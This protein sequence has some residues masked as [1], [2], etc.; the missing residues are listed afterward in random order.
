MP[1]RNRHDVAV[2]GAG[3]A[4][5]AVAYALARRRIDVVILDASRRD[6]GLPGPASAPVQ[7]GT[8]DDIRLTLRSVEMLPALQDSVGPFGYLRTGGLTAALT[9]GEAEVGRARVDEAAGLPLS[10]LTADEARRR[11]PALTEQ[12]AGAVYC[13]YDGQLDSAAL[14]ERLLAAAAR[15]GAAVAADAG[16]VMVARQNGGFRIRAGHDELV[17]RKIV[18]ASP[19]LMPAAGRSLEVDVPLRVARRRVGVTERH[20]PLIRHAVNGI[21][22]APAGQIVLD[23]PRLT[24]DAASQA[25]APELVEALRR[26]AAAAVRVLPGL[27]AARLHH[28]PLWTSVE[29]ADGRPAVGRLQTDVYAALAGPDQAPALCPLIG[30]LVAEMIARNRPPEDI[31][32]WAADRFAAAAAGL[33]SDRRTS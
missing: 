3:C 2:L 14:I 26:I 5:A 15:L 21:F 32:V 25:A 29:P 20:A 7:R 13:A 28:A 9:A 18:L 27:E 17:A 11:E 8:A 16:Y 12:T 1:D 23:P 24:D 30:E 33:P 19:E 31:D 10:W 4:G 6:A 22:Q